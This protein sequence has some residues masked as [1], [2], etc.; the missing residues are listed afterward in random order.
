MSLDVL[1][2]VTARTMRLPFRMWG[3]GEAVALEGLLSAAARL[4]DRQPLGFVDALVRATVARGIG[5][6]LE[7]H[8]APG[9][10]MLSRYRQ[11]GEPY[12]LG[13][14][15]KLAEVY[16]SLPENQY[17]ARLHRFWQPGWKDQIWVDQMDV[18]APFLAT[19]FTISNEEIYLRRATQE[20]LAYARLLQDETN[21]L[22]WHGYESACGRNGE[23]WARGNGWAARGM[24][25]TLAAIPATDPARPEI[26][27]RLT[28]H[29][30]GLARLQ[31]G[32]G[33]WHTVLDDP[34]TC[35]ETT[36]AAMIAWTIPAIRCQGLETREFETMAG[37]A[38][39][40]VL[41]QIDGEG[42]LQLVSDATPIGTRR[43][44]ATRPFGIFPWGQGPLLLML[45]METEGKNENR[46]G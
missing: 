24:A 31:D 16:N 27:E 33:L 32:S 20:L 15:R 43:M 35:L 46:E 25:Q 29:L 34:A 4:Q 45:S 30:R 40:A 7:D 11:T 23:L 28:A 9:M 37:A 39:A 44:Y 6:H 42:A 21:G 3:F 26:V 17:G 41:G 10:S 13:G 1:R 18:G 5:S 14:A 19:L 12:Y 2:T 36:L 22:M 38:Y 8:V